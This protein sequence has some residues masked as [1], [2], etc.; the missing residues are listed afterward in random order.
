M[1]FEFRTKSNLTFLFNKFIFIPKVIILYGTLGSQSK[2]VPLI[3]LCARDHCQAW[4]S[5]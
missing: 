1:G 5:L 2:I 3:E 4:P